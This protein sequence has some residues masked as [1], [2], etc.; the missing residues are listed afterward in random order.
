MCT[1]EQ[2]S[3]QMS[4][5]FLLNRCW[6]MHLVIHCLLPLIKSCGIKIS[7]MRSSMTWPEICEVQLVTCKRAVTFRSKMVHFVNF[8]QTKGMREYVHKSCYIHILC[9]YIPG[10]MVLWNDLLQDMEYLRGH[11]VSISTNKSS[12]LSSGIPISVERVFSRCSKSCE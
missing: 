3:I 6:Q 2:I 9:D 11:Q 1:L 8:L 4:M 7:C 10:W 12:F 5:F